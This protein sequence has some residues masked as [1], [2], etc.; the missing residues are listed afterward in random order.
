MQWL[1]DSDPSIRWQV[2]RDLTGEPAEVVAAE[3]SRVA[4]EGWGAHLLGQ[5]RPDG[6]WGDDIA[7][8]HWRSNLFTLLL[9]RGLGL[10]SVTRRSSTAKS[11]PA[12]T[13]AFSRWA[14]TSERPE[15][16]WSTGCWASSSRTAGGTARRS[17][18][19]CAPRSTP[20]SAFWRDSWSTRRPKAPRPR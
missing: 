9:L 6:N 12:S 13:V 2:M 5:Q 10:D 1:L 17:G 11:S 18:A 8:P 15:I 16:P 19:L 3:R 14:A 4:S 20:R 7:T